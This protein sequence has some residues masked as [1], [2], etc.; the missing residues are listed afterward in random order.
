[1]SH[2]ALSVPATL[3]APLM[4][5]LDRMGPAAKHVAQTGAAIGREFGFHLL[6]SVSD[7]SERLLH[8][9]L[10]RLTNSGMLFA[11]GTPPQST[12]IFKHALLQDAA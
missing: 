1:M 7:L 9:A 10:D 12:Y 5:R 4:A 2:P 3:H 6:A 8:D 11:R